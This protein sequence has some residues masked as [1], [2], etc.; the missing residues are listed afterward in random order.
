MR[1]AA[2]PQ[3]EFQAEIVPLGLGAMK[4]VRGGSWA[5]PSQDRGFVIL[6]NIIPTLKFFK[7][8]FKI[9]I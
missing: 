5:R 9:W 8:L 6:E 7:Y 1:T 3:L 4:T 2:L